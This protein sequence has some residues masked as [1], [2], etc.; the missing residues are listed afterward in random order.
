MSRWSSNSKYWASNI[1]NRV[2]AQRMPY[3]VQVVIQTKGLSL[4]VSKG[5]RILYLA[6]CYLEKFGYLQPNFHLETDF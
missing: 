2:K 1:S 3:F 4:L 5:Q 6:R